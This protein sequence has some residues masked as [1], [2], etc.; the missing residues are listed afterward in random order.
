MSKVYPI[1]SG[2]CEK[3]SD[4]LDPMYTGEEVIP[5]DALCVAPKEEGGVNPAGD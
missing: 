1:S 3:R 4:E 2:V 5:A